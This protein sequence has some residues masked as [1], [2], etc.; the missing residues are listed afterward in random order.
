MLHEN[1]L[2][3]GSQW[4]KLYALDA[5]SGEILWTNNDDQLH[6]F[7]M[8]PAASDGF[9]FTGSGN[10]LY[11]IHAASGRTVKYKEIPGYTFQSATTP[12]AENGILYLG[13]ADRGVVAVDMESLELLWTFETG[14]SL[15]YTS[16]YSNGDLATIDSAIVPVAGECLC[17]GASDGWLYLIDK[18][19]SLL[20]KFDVGSP[21]NQA[22]IAESGF[23]IAADFSG[24]I[25]R[26][27]I[28]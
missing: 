17:F 8:T 12:Y 11:K 24:N 4:N 13:T 5:A 15:I 18:K 7:I 28:R 1:K 25:T 14:R 3:V 6:N 10:R 19:G 16:P 23:I 27:D 22:P 20:R 9:L 26:Y 21:I 2:F